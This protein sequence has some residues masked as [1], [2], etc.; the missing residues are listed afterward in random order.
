LTTADTGPRTPVRVAVTPRLPAASVARLDEDP[1]TEEASVLADQTLMERTRAAYDVRLQRY[2]TALGRRNA[3]YLEV[4][5]G[6]GKELIVLDA[7]LWQQLFD[8]Y[9]Y[10]GWEGIR[11][12]DT[13]IRSLFRRR[14]PPTSVWAPAVRFYEQTRTLLGGLVRDTLADQERL[15]AVRIT[16]RLSVSAV[17][18]ESAWTHYGVV[19][20]V[21]T[22]ERPVGA[23]ATA[24]EDIETFAFTQEAPT[25]ALFE[26]LTAAVGQR[27]AYEAE[28]QRVADMRT[29]IKRLRDM[30]QR[31]RARGRPLSSEA[32]LVRELDV[33][34]EETARLEETAT[35]LYVGILQI[36]NDHSPFGALALE[37]LAP[38]FTRD[39]M[40]SVLGAALWQL[41][42]RLDVLGGQIDEDRSKV[43]LLLPGTSLVDPDRPGP[44]A[45]T[46]PV[47]GPERAVVDAA[48]ERLGKDGGWFPLVHEPTLH[49]LVED[50]QIPVDSWAYTVWSHYV[51]TLA[52]VLAERR[53]Q[54]DA[55]T[56]FW[57][58]F[59]KGAAVASLALL[60]SPAPEFAVP[61]RGAVAVADFILLVHTITSVT[62]QLAQLA[63]LQNQ[64]LV[65]PDAFSVE[66][67]GRLGE[68]GVHRQRLLAGLTQQLLIELA[69]TAAGARWP[70][71]KEG[72]LLRGYY[73]D[74][75]TLLGEED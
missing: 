62:G 21:T 4:A 47:E 18:L 65:H 19:R 29:H 61:L 33:T 68:L 67:L 28:L 26:A 60:T 38:G 15:C 39:R 69:L 20:T 50:E 59:S 70:V 74:L 48:I 24:E 64:Q 35:A 37:A 2:A 30:T 57:S 23:D 13:A 41:H 56:A 44:D 58:A 54:D 71:I 10:D 22:V 34:E 6:G 14:I 55:R 36:M 5:N 17:A 52:R 72:L 16:T 46:V 66:G 51:S 53:L 75:D 31:A 45:L 43:G 8:L 63:E 9:L 7:G 32:Q 27:V 25:Q 1:D 3:P 73:Q 12:V 49:Q 40:E 11:R 42:A